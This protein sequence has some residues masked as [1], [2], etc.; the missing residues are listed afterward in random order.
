MVTADACINLLAD[1]RDA[2]FYKSGSVTF[3]KAAMYAAAA[4]GVIAQW[5]GHTSFA[6]SDAPKDLYADLLNHTVISVYL[7]KYLSDQPQIK[8]WVPLAGGPVTTTIAPA[9]Q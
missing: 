5:F 7:D 9:A 4:P 6:R 3:N 8:C 1:A 2:L